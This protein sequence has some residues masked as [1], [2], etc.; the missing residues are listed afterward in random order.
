MNETLTWKYV[1]GEGLTLRGASAQ[2]GF[3]VIV[4]AA[5]LFVVFGALFAAQELVFLWFLLPLVVAFVL[6]ILAFRNRGTVVEAT[7]TLCPGDVEIKQGS[8]IRTVPLSRIRWYSL[9][10]DDSLSIVKPAAVRKAITTT[11]AEGKLPLT[12]IY[13]KLRG[14]FW[15]LPMYTNADMHAQATAWLE[16]HGIPHSSHAT[17]QLRP[18]GKYIRIAFYFLMGLFVIFSFAMAIFSRE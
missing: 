13:L 5:F 15:S 10:G 17:G 4:S 9:Y 16:S 6:I 11:Q 18:F 14:S 3:Q 8:S 2:Q 1:K 12:A 7:Y